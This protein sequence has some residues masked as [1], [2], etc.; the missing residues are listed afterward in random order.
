[1]IESAGHVLRNM[2][3]ASCSSEYGDTGNAGNAECRADEPGA[4]MSG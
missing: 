4:I 1:V 3:L 2:F